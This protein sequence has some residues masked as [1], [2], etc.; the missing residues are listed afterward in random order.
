MTRKQPQ[1]MY[2]GDQFNYT[3]SV[4]ATKMFACVRVCSTPANNIMVDKIQK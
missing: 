3:M 4:E 1:T 2:D